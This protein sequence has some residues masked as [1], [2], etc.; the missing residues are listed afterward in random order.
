[1]NFTEIELFENP[2]N[3]KCRWVGTVKAYLSFYRITDGAMSALHGMIC[4]SFLKVKWLSYQ[5]WKNF[6]GEDVILNSDVAIFAAARESISYKGHYN[7]TDAG[8]D[9]MMSGC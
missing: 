7:S 6:Y 3:D 8:E 5:H 9:A 2:S 4:C 1:M